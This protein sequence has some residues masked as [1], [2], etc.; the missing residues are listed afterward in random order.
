MCCDSP[1]LELVGE[2]LCGVALVFCYNCGAAYHVTLGTTACTE[3]TTRW[4]EVV[5]YA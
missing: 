5:K 1:D 2:V 3:V 4:I